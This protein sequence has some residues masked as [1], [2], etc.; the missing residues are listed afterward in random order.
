MSTL[1]FDRRRRAVSRDTVINNLSLG[2]A[3]QRLT[4]LAPDDVQ[5]VEAIVKD[6]LRRHWPSDE[7]PVDKGA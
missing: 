3:L 2:D 1:R 6:A 7:Q 5:A 4:L